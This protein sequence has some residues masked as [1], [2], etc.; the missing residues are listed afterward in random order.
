MLHAGLEGAAD[1]RTPEDG[2]IGI[3][4]HGVAHEAAQYLSAWRPNRSGC[5]DSRQPLIE[6]W[7]D[8]DN[9]Q[10]RHR[11]EKPLAE[12]RVTSSSVFSD[13]F[14]AS[15]PSIALSSSGTA[16]DQ[17]ITVCGA[18]CI[19]ASPCRPDRSNHGGCYSP[20]PR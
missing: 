17:C 20:L 4:G 7:H 13:H 15:A 8:A 2:D 18:T 16:D 12:T 9:G 3:D 5:P 11:S 6:S 14:G 19:S 10:M 1:L